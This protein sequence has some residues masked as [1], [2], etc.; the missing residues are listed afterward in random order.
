[1]RNAG[2]RS[3]KVEQNKNREGS[4]NTFGGNLNG[5]IF[6]DMKI[7]SVI[8]FFLWPD[9]DDAYVPRPVQPERLPTT[10]A[11]L[12]AQPSKAVKL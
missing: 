2:E 12:G 8:L 4:S 10:V 3:S 5:T 9:P 6:I 7:I 11:A 1:M